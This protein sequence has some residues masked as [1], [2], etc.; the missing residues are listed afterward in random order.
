MLWTSL[1]IKP[2]FP[3]GYASSVDL[4]FMCS[5][6]QKGSMSK[7][8]SRVMRKDADAASIS[9][10]SGD[11]RTLQHRVWQFHTKLG[12]KANLAEKVQEGNH[13][14]VKSAKKGAHRQNKG[15]LQSLPTDLFH[16]SLYGGTKSKLWVKDECKTVLNE[17]ITPTIAKTQATGQLK[18]KWFTKNKADKRLTAI[19]D[20]EW[21]H[22]VKSLECPEVCSEWAFKATLK[23]RVQ[24]PQH[25]LQELQILL[26]VPEKS[27]SSRI[28]PDQAKKNKKHT[29]QKSTKRKMAR[30][31]S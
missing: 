23:S 14:V 13:S 20:K 8:P 1:P 21:K 16:G 3:G 19:V 7:C 12:S 17:P 25:K 2:P 6:C 24:P 27:Y 31:E 30:E 5:T 15:T 26:C 11:W 10:S 9:Y 22:L 18:T 4:L 29:Q 28:V